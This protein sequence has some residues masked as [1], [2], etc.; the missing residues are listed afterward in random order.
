MQSMFLRKQIAIWY[1]EKAIYVVTHYEHMQALIGDKKATQYF[2]TFG[3]DPD[4]PYEEWSS[5]RE[6]TNSGFA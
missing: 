5:K 6:K 3:F 1:I 2:K 4:Q